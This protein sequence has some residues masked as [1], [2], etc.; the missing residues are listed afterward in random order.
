MGGTHSLGTIFKVTTTGGESVVH[1]FAGGKD[2]AIGERLAD[3][4]PSVLNGKLYGA[5]PSGGGAENYGT[6]YTIAP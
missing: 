4:G 1:S 3:T 5:T 6:V 2:G